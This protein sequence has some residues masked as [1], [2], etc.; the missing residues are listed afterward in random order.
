MEKRTDQELMKLI[1]EKNTLALKALYRRYEIPIFNFILRYTGSREIARELIQETFTRL[2]FASHLFDQK[3]GNFKGWLYTIA[4]NIT[5][6]EMSKKEYTYQY[7]EVNEACNPENEGDR[8]EKE[9]PETI[10]QQQELQHTVANALGQLQPYLREVII[11]KNYQHLKFREIA[12]VTNVPEGTIKARYHR[13]I[14]L[15]KKSLNPEPNKTWRTE[16][17]VT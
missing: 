12:K 2:W 1:T 13:A 3:R 10:L 9:S 6:N 4:L 5:R 17:C 8:R 16:P 7:V 11:M 15:L 14:A